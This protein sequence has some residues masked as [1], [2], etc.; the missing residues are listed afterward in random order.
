MGKLKDSLQQHLETD[1]L[2]AEQYWQIQDQS[3]PEPPLPDG[4]TAWATPH[5]RLPLNRTVNST[6]NAEPPF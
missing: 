4:D 2:F 5:T 1:R 3:F 6:F